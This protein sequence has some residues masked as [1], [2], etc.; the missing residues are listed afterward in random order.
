MGKGQVLVFSFYS[1]AGT[2]IHKA[3][4]PI[5]KSLQKIKVTTPQL[6]P[7]SYHCTISRYFA[8]PAVLEKV[9]L[10]GQFRSSYAE[11]AGVS[12]VKNRLDTLLHVKEPMTVTKAVLKLKEGIVSTKLVRRDGANRVGNSPAFHGELTLPRKSEKVK[13]ALRQRG[14]DQVLEPMLNATV[15]MLSPSQG[16]LYRG[17]VDIQKA[18]SPQEEVVLNYADEQISIIAYPNI[19]QWDQ[20][21]TDRIDFE[22][23]FPLEKVIPSERELKGTDAN[24]Y[25]D[26]VVELSFDLPEDVQFQGLEEI[27]G[28]IELRGSDD[29]ILEVIPIQFKLD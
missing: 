25:A 3:T 23:S 17:W 11:V 20:L 8:K 27:Y 12:F 13:I 1:E 28:Q 16:T 24:F 2:G 29:S 7:G 10:M 22:V 9:H 15:A 5:Q 14:Y 21:S 26:R 4:V 6:P 18:G 19:V